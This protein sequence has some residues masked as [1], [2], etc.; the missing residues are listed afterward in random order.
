MTQPGET[1]KYKL[2][3]HLKAIIKHTGP[4]I[5]DYVVVNNQ[6]VPNN[7]LEKYEN[8]GAYP[9]DTDKAEIK[10]LGVKIVKANI[11]NSQ[12]YIRHN[13]KRLAK[14][15]LDIVSSVF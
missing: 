11:I 5:V 14:I 9:V 13:P 2:S 7:L 12:D 4:G 10:R 15:I 8:E 3:D 6:K 1:D